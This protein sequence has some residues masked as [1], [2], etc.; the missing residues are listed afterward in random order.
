[1]CDFFWPRVESNRGELEDV[2]R[3]G[4]RSGSQ[5]EPAATAEEDMGFPLSRSL[6]VEDPNLVHLPLEFLDVGGEQE[7]LNRPCDD[8]LRVLQIS[9][10]RPSQQ[11][12]PVVVMAGTP[13]DH[14]GGL[15]EISS[16]MAQGIKRRKS[17]AKR[18]VCI[19]APIVAATGR[20]SGEVVP[21]DLWAWRKYGQKPI[22][23]SPY[24]R[25][26]YRC[27]SSK[28]CSAR[29][30]VERSRTDPNMLVITYTSEHNHPWPTHRNAFA[31]S[32]RC[33]APKNHPKPTLEEPVECVKQEA[34]HIESTEH[35]ATMD[36]VAEEE[37]DFDLT[38]NN[39]TADELIGFKGVGLT[40]RTL[41]MEGNSR[42]DKSLM[43]MF[44]WS[45]ALDLN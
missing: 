45:E 38:T 36:R 29:K 23:G 1:M 5:L 17:Q 14:G 21:S 10:G 20:P 12:L 43:D 13:V 16:P 22:K 34:L 25:G 26:Y 32:T 4:S 8:L 27:S 19:P 18:V 15:L 39:Q 42:G 3:S 44:D 37:V 9:P 28:G 35:K 6:G 24:P 2:V 7:S 33:H 11:A 40:S 31:G 41:D 30:Q